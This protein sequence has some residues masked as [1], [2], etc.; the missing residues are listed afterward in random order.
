MI[1]RLKPAFGGAELA[2]AL[3]W[4]SPE[5]VPAFERE[6]AAAFEARD[7]VAFPYG[8]TALKALLHALDLKDAEVIAPS[9]TCVVVQHATLLSGNVPVFVDNTMTDYNMDLDRFAAAITPKT[10]A[11]LATHLFGFPLDL[12][13][14]RAIVSEAEQRFGRKIWVI[15]DCA[16]AFGAR[17]KGRLVCNDG[18]A[19]LFGLNISKMLSSIFGG[20]LTF[21]DGELAAKVRAWRDA[22][23]V[24]GTNVKSAL[25]LAY[26]L[27]T[28]PAF[29]RIPYGLVH[30][31]QY[32]TTVLDRLTKAYHLDEEVRFPPDANER[33]LPIEAR[34]GRVQLTRRE[35]IVQRRRA[36]AARYTVGLAGV[37]GWTLPPLVDG[38][39]YSH[40]PVRVPDRQAAV[41]YFAAR[42]VHLGEV[43]EYSVAHLNAYEPYAAGQQFPN[44]LY[45][46]A[47]MVNLPIHPQ[48]DDADVDRVIA[49]AREIR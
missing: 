34:V 43:V 47:H 25:R 35:W 2:A 4:G 5:D 15:Q 22:N 37:P 24:P 36:I 21:T 46:S 39:T 12:D 44:S 19:A 6:F 33:M 45:C 20:M 16:H 28:Y 8:R 17:W 41:D 3:R 26:L 7:A 10:G 9:Y 32:R 42:G 18:D 13:R 30:F 38:A 40:Y 29:A 1:P 14:F 23:L 49:I 11:I 27:A 48:L 31:L